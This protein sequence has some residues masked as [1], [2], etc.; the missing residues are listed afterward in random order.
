M[1]RAL[2]NGVLSGMS[3]DGKK[4]FY[5]NPLEVWPEACD[6][7][8]DLSHVKYD[9]QSWFGCACCPPNIA[10]LLASISDYI[11]VQ[12]GNDVFVNLF[13]GGDA[14]F[15]I[16]EQVVQIA[17]IANYPWKE[18]IQFEISVK[19]DTEF[20]LAL[21]IPS[22][23]DQPQVSIN[24]N[25][26]EFNL[27][28]HIENGYVRLNRIW[29]H[30]DRITLILPMTAT[31][32]MAHPNLKNNLGKIAL[33]RGPIVYCLEEVDN[34]KH[35]TQVTLPKHSKISTIYD[36]DIFE[37]IPILTGEAKRIDTL[38]WDN[39]L[40]KSTEYVNE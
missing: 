26:E 24:V 14:E 8:S 12:K 19:E 10:R 1:E 6:H 20:T 7:R 35:L 37:G 27:S 39:E 31:K 21:R 25:G 29:N 34:G 28:S 16:N 18:K 30:K 22:W 13:I 36:D 5:V 15:K 38:G 33:Q 4:Y 11:Y 3:Q 32:V 2:Y 23:C 9:R 40:Y 17:T